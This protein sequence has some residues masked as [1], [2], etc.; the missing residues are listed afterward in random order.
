MLFT[1]HFRLIPAAVAALAALLSMTPAF[2]ADV[3]IGARTLRVA[4]GYSVELAVDSSLVGR[5]IAVARDERGRLY[6]TDSGGMSERAEKQLELKP[7][8]IRRVEDTNGDGVYDKSVLFADKMMFPEGCLWY[9]GSL[10]V[11]A[12]P[13]IWK[14][15][16]T[17]DDGSADKREVWFDGKL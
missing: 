8:N 4:D 7:H 13:E 3:T 11:A 2:S 9:E 17:D 12:P 6:V 10:Y 5:P 15:T 14:L 16:D 1:A